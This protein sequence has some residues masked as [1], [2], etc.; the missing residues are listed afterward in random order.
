MATSIEPE[1]LEGLFLY[2]LKLL[3]VGW[4]LVPIC[5]TLLGKRPF[6]ACHCCL[7]RCMHYVRTHFLC[8]TAYCCFHCWRTGPTLLPR[9]DVCF[10]YLNFAA[11][12]VGAY[13][14]IL[15]FFLL[16]SFFFC[17]MMRSSKYYTNH[18]PHQNIVVYRVM[19]ALLRKYNAYK[20]LNTE[21]P[22]KFITTV[23][24]INGSKKI[25]NCPCH[26]HGKF[27][28]KLVREHLQRFCLTKA[29]YQPTAMITSSINW[30]MVRL[31]IGNGQMLA[32]INW[33]TDTCQY[34]G[35]R[36][37]EWRHCGQSIRLLVCN[38]LR[39]YS[40]NILFFSYLNK[41]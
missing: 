17:L 40:L 35:F 2:Y 37:S 10:F 9:D 26:Y 27:T 23:L 6:W 34:W 1:F 19:P 32:S 14:Y 8:L 24:W 31:S 12:F 39:T 21:K 25:R 7:G 41:S 22:K 29:N 15:L 18:A 11:P 13:Y 16:S 5:P 36:R 30:Y 38:L 4:S 28:P 3:D 33:A 20:N